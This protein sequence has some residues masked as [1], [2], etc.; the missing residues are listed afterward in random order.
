MYM[1]EEEYPGA[2]AE[3][4]T[5]LE[6]KPN[7]DLLM[8]TESVRTGELWFGFKSIGSRSLRASRSK[9]EKYLIAS[10]KTVQFKLSRPRISTQLFCQ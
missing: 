6:D 5:N 2:D 10:L 9:V 3:Y 7:L 8:G 4:G 1:P